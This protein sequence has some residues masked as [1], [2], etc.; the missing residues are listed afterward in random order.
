LGYKSQR[1]GLWVLTGQ[2]K[3]VGYTCIL[4]LIELKVWNPFKCDALA[5][6]YNG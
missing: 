6:S 3:H 4:V 1:S 2:K 5:L